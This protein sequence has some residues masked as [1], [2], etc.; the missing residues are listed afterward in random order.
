[1]RV[2]L[3]RSSR[4]RTKMLGEGRSASGNVFGERAGDDARVGRAL[5]PCNR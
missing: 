2:R 5:R 3:R 1:M 4:L